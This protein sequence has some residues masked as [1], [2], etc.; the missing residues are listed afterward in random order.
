MHDDY[1]EPNLLGYPVNLPEVEAI[2][3]KEGLPF[4]K[5]EGALRCELNLLGRGYALAYFLPAS[6][7]FSPDENER[8]TVTHS[9]FRHLQHA[10]LQEELAKRPSKQL[11]LFFVL[12]GTPLTKAQVNVRWTLQSDAASAVKVFLQPDDIRNW[13]TSPFRM[14]QGSARANAKPTLTTLRD[15]TGWE[16]PAEPVAPFAPATTVFKPDE[17]LE[18]VHADFCG[19]CFQDREMTERLYRFI[20]GPTYRVFW[21]EAGPGL[22]QEGDDR[23][24]PLFFTSASERIVFAYAAYLARTARTVTPGMVVGIY[25]VLNALD[26]LRMVAALDCLQHLVVATGASVVVESA[27]TE[28]RSLTKFRL[29]DAFSVTANNAEALMADAND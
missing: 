20:M 22:G 23:G 11:F 4:S 29:A 26:T 1:Q 14:L 25:L 2:L 5:V 24:I 21:G 6:A 18:N 12:D 28:V 16:N 7:A 17:V 10:L 15:F 8:L 9:K 19:D 3:Q 13:I 27:K